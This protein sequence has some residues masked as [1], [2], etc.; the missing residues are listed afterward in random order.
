MRQALASSKQRDMANLVPVAGRSL[1]QD[2]RGYIRL[3]TL[4]Y[5][6]S[7]PV[8]ILSHYADDPIKESLPSTEKYF[9]WGD[10]TAINLNRGFT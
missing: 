8:G 10:E 6:D 4:F 7:W 2:Y 1:E 9:V 5:I 3:D